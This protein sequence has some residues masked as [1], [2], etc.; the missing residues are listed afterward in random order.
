MTIKRIRRGVSAQ[1]MN[2]LPLKRTSPNR[3]TSLVLYFYFIRFQ[4]LL[5]RE[6]CRGVTISNHLHSTHIVAGRYLRKFHP[7][8]SQNVDQSG[9]LRFGALFAL[10]GQC[11]QRRGQGLPP[12]TCYRFAVSTAVSVC[13]QRSLPNTQISMTAPAILRSLAGAGPS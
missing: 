6:E 1:K 2:R 8:N 10:R 5:G 3:G 4:T 13:T 12:L 11:V 9:Q 7:I